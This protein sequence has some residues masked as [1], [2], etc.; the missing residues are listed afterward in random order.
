M[1]KEQKIKMLE[2]LI[3]KAHF[4]TNCDLD[5]IIF[6][7]WKYSAKR[8]IFKIFGENSV[9][10]KQYK[11]FFL[12]NLLFNN[13]ED[14]AES[15]KQDLEKLIKVISSLIEEIKY[16]EENDNSILDT[17]NCNRV[18]ISHSSKDKQIVTELVDVLT[19]FGLTSTQIFCS[20]FEG[21]GIPLGNNPIETLKKEI[22]KNVLVLFVLTNNFY[23]SSFCLFEMGA[24]W[25][26][27]KE[28]IPIVVPPFTFNEMNQK[29]QLSQGIIINDKLQLNSFREKIMTMFK[30]VSQEPISIW[31]QKRDRYIQRI[32]SILE[33]E[34][35]PDFDT[36]ARGNHNHE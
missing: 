33:I 24:T 34:E 15:H 10:S 13:R 20:S 22:N 12:A 9:E 1:I 36:L 6:T 32:N 30:M 28:H 18:F 26:L 14:V 3:D 5:D 16:F 27:S 19:S 23:E 25:A 21:C 29:L 8:T 11:S 17:D 4:I 2:N 31:E 7:D 35:I